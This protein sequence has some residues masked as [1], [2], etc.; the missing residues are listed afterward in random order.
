[1]RWKPF[2]GL[3]LSIAGLTITHH[4]MAAGGIVDSIVQPYQS[5][6]VQLAQKA[7]TYASH[8]FWLLAA[9]QFSASSIRLALSGSDLQ[10]W[11]AH[12]VRQILFVGIYAWIMENFYNFSELIISSFKQVAT[13]STVSPSNVFQVGLK[14]AATIYSNAGIGHP[15]S[16]VV[17]GIG[18]LVIALC[19][20]WIAALVI[21]ALCEAYILI[22][23]GVLMTGLGGSEWTRDFSNKA[24]MMSMSVGAKIFIMYTLIDV[25]WTV[26]NS[27]T[28]LDYSQD[29]TVFQ[30]VAAVFIYVLIVL[31]LPNLAQQFISGAA[32]GST[33]AEG[34][35]SITQ[36]AA[37]AALAATGVGMAGAAAYNAASAGTEGAGAMAGAG[38]GGA[39]GG[40]AAMAGGGAGEA[41]GA[42]MGGS[43][44]ASPATQAGVGLGQI[45]RALGQ[46]IKSEV[47]GRMTG[48]GIR[49]GT[50]GGRVAHYIAKNQEAPP[51]PP[52]NESPPDENRIS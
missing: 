7:L 4:A 22:A 28:N 37:T 30:V 26:M 47:Y 44:G 33:A 52:S 15:L 41:E 27:W 34:I 21:V 25:G 36:A 20:G 5:A 32:T 24:L 48:T 23:A 12:V 2:V 42:R 11:V 19:F 51:P 35:K 18:A 8:T 45:G 40:G 46:G 1:M 17:Y 14:I 50:L 29:T 6:G 3:G 43:Q 49:G 13:A 38:A 31:Q 10:E 16:A 9:I 39:E